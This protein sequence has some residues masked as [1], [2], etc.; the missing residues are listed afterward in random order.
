MILRQLALAIGLLMGL[1]TSQLPE[2]AQQYRQRL[3]GAIDE[4]NR[5][6]AEFDADAAAVKLSREQGVERLSANPDPLAS[7]RGARV[8]EDGARAARLERQLSAFQTAGPVGRLGVLAADIDPRVASRA[9]SSF[10]P[11]LPLTLEGAVLAFLGFLSGWGLVRVAA[12]PFRRRVR[13]AG[14]GVRV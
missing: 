7:Q 14:S 13:P 2:F 4:I 12:K 6:L 9:W 11:A 8:R 5:M 1:V 3:G 10:E